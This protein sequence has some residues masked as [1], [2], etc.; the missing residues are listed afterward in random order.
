MKFKLP[1]PVGIGWS[2]G[3]AL[4][5]ALQVVIYRETLQEAIRYGRKRLLV[6]KTMHRRFANQRLKRLNSLGDDRKSQWMWKNVS[7][8]DAA[9]ADNDTISEESADSTAGT[10]G[11]ISSQKKLVLVMVGL[12]ARGKSFVVHKTL[13]YIEWLGF[14]TRVFNV[15]NLRRQLGKAGENSTFFSA[16]NKDATNLRE[17][18]AMNALDNLLEWIEDKGHVAVFDATNTTK[19]R[20]QH[21]LEKVSSHQNVRVMFVESICDSKKLLEINYR[22][23]LTNADYKDKD[24]EEALA[25][26]RQR[27]HEYGK[28]Y[29]TVE[30]TEDSGNACYV[31]VYNAG[32]KIQARYCQGFLQSQIVSLLQNI[33]LC[34]RRIWLVRPGPSITSCKGILG[35]DTELSPEG[36]RVA[37]AIASFVENLQLVRPMEVWSSPMKRARETAEYLPTRELKR[38]VLTTLLNELGGGDFE[39]LTYDEIEHLY[40]KHYVARLQDK[41][42]YRYPGVGGESYVD[43]ISRLRSLIIEFERKKR[44]VLVICSESILRCLLGYF[45]GCE[46]AKVPHLQSYDNTIVE[47]S[48]HR[49]GCDIKLI[50]LKI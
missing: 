37:R 19:L 49:D 48:P 26:F 44:D 21:I 47:L 29:E 31:K 5:L 17:K 23:K 2:M 16:D 14:P 18:M 27:V 22:R 32:E 9:F 11:L 10:D 13:R 41:L 30:D 24:P 28:V 35:L 43:V 46:A 34:P 3:L 42:R 6:Y 12:P 45:A 39:G 36:H 33:H 4:A 38:Y 25:D 7:Q 8:N 15:G 1:T 50:P 20:R 40:P